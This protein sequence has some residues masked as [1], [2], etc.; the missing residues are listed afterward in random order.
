MNDMST[1]MST[2]TNG[3]VSLHGVNLKLKDL[4]AHIAAELAAGLSD[5]TGICKRYGIS[6]EQWEALRKNPMFRGMVKEAIETWQ[7][8]LNANRRIKL[9]AAI[10]TE[11][12][13]TE[14]YRMVFDDALPAP[15]RVEAQKQLSRLAGVDHVEG[16]GTGDG[17][18]I[19]INF[20]GGPVTA[21]SGPTPIEGTS[22]PMDS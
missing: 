14:L 9:K 1:D 2:S 4:S 11:D 3:D 18:S 21:A 10:A 5:A 6:P 20:P 15:S 22:T 16:K 13:I 7:G 8:D 17:F 12:T 19:V